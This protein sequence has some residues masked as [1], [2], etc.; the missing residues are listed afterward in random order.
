MDGA[1][2]QGDE[3]EEEGKGHE[4]RVDDQFVGLEHGSPETASS[5]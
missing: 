1:E 3:T 4:D 2:E 5:S